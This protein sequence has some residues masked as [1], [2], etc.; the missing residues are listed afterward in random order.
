MKLNKHQKQFLQ[1]QKNKIAD[2]VSK[3]S[4]IFIDTLVEL[5]IDE[6]SKECGFLSDFLFIEEISFAE[7]QKSLDK[8]SNNNQKGNDNPFS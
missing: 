2:L 4:A 3:Q 6:K 5:N 8:I 1:A 7:F